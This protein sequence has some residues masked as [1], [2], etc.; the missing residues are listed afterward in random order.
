MQGKRQ[1]PPKPD[2]PQKVPEQKMTV[3]ALDPE[4]VFRLVDVSAVVANGLLGGAVARAFRFDLVGFL[5]LATITGMGGG[6]IRDVLLNTG[7]P[8]ALTDS[9]Y[10][11]AAVGA[12]VLA[13]TIDLGTRWADRTLMV[14]DFLGMGCW[15]ATGTTKAL[16]VG[17]NWFPAIVL[18][19]VTAV[20]GGMIRDIMVNRIPAIFGGSSLYA[21][22]ALFGASLTAFCTLVLEAQTLGFA[23]SIFLCLTLGL[24][25]RWRNWTLP[26]PVALKVPRPKLRRNRKSGTVTLVE[27]E[28]GWVPGSPITEAIPVIDPSKLPHQN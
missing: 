24:L 14:V 18:G 9:A 23:L 6:L 26:E 27:R 28:E 25:A 13:Y 11:I 12:A 19:V 5:L 1:K 4:T 3:T 15:V 16:S 22:V 17:L 21:T 10:W 2:K 20:G 7:L 8:V